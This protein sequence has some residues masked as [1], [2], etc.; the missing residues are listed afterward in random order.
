MAAALAALRSPASSATGG[1]PHDA[2]YMPAPVPAAAPM[3]QRTLNG[4]GRRARREKRPMAPRTR[5]AAI[6]AR[7]AGPARAT[8]PRSLK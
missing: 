8:T 2:P 4:T 3:V 5:S 6:G 7:L 1:A